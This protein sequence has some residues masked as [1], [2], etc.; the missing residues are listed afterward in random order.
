MHAFGLVCLCV[1]LLSLLAQP[2]H[3]Q[4]Y[5][6]F[7][8]S[9]ARKKV[10]LIERDYSRGYSSCFVL[11]CFSFI[12]SASPLLRWTKEFCRTP[13]NALWRDTHETCVSICFST[14][15]SWRF[16]CFLTFVFACS[17]THPPENPPYKCVYIFISSLFCS[18]IV[19]QAFSF[20]SLLNGMSAKPPHHS[21]ALFSQKHLP[22]FKKKNIIL[23]FKKKLKGKIWLDS[24][25]RAN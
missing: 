20:A 21:F 9:Y 10:S 15:D 22:L 3:L 16:T 1:F 23:V 8:L 25:A 17:R 24:Q 12:V 5:H 14:C 4:P 13:F 19:T 18:L 2:A 7:P 11:F 6:G